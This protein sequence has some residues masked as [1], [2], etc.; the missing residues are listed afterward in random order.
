MRQSVIFYINITVV[1]AVMKDF[2]FVDLKSRNADQV[3][4]C[5]T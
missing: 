3:V 4:Q 5:L 1:V 2:V